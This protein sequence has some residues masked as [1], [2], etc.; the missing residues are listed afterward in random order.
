MTQFQTFYSYHSLTFF[1]PPHMM[2]ISTL[3]SEQ[4]LSQKNK[5][6]EVDFSMLG[7]RI[8]N[9]VY[10]YFF[11]ISCIIFANSPLGETHKKMRRD[12]AMEIFGRVQIYKLKGFFK[13]KL[14]FVFLIKKNV[15]SRLQ[16][17]Q[18]LIYKNI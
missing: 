9:L 1:S 18:T 6:G 15:K 4:K 7:Q 8:K 14:W 13:I 17:P 2:T 12:V 16:Q 5:R 11:I 3:W 10:C